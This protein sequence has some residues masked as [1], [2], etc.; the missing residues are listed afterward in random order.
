[1]SIRG[2]HNTAVRGRISCAMS[3]LARSRPPTTIV[4]PSAALIAIVTCCGLLRASV[5][6]M[7]RDTDLATWLRKTKHHAIARGIRADPRR[8]VDADGV[9][10]S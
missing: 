6:R 3:P 8:P 1:M 2:I 5:V 10:A 4:S 7:K 9:S